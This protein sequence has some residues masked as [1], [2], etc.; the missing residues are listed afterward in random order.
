MIYD[1]YD[2]G[3]FFY[4]RKRENKIIR[5]LTKKRRSVLENK[6]GMYCAYPT[7]EK[8]FRL[9]KKIY[10]FSIFISEANTDKNLIF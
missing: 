9:Y 5:K 8:F 10:Q 7:E 1:Y 2:K 4:Y 3:L 6:H